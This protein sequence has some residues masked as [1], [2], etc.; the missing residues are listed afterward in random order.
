M[1]TKYI[2]YR[3]LGKLILFEAGM[4]QYL[5]FYEYGVVG[6][7]FNRLSY[8]ACEVFRIGNWKL[9]IYSISFVLHKVDKS[10]GF[11]HQGIFSI[12]A[13]IWSPSTDK[14]F[15]A[16]GISVWANPK[17]H[18]EDDLV[19]YCRS[20]PHI[21]ASIISVTVQLIVIAV[22]CVDGNIFLPKLPT[23]KNVKNW[24]L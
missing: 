10:N 20:S 2:I 6:G 17:E 21:K 15:F 24:S 19:W 9:F 23:H 5:N 8:L 18:R 13:R 7:G 11:N 1:S 3:N 14:Y 4:H 22:K 16:A 12:Q